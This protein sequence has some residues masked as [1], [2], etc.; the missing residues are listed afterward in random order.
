ML[1]MALLLLQTGGT[2]LHPPKMLP[3]SVKPTGVWKLGSQAKTGAIQLNAGRNGR[4]LISGNETLVNQGFVPMD[5]VV[6]GTGLFWYVVL[7]EKKNG[8]TAFRATAFKPGR[9]YTVYGTA[10]GRKSGKMTQD[11]LATL[12]TI[13]AL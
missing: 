7:D 1:A 12:K 10:E 6:R 4:L 9:R 2:A 13:Q 5:Q 11:A 3:V 8:Q